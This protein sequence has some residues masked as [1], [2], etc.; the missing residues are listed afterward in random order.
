MGFTTGANLTPP[1]KRAA[2][3][4]PRRSVSAVHRRKGAS[5]TNPNATSTVI[6]WSVPFLPHRRHRHRRAHVVMP[7][8]RQ[9]LANRVAEPCASDRN[10]RSAASESTAAAEALRLPNGVSI[11]SPTAGMTAILPPEATWQQLTDAIAL[12]A[13][14]FQGGAA[15]SCEEAADADDSGRLDLTDAIYLVE[16][17]F[18]TGVAPPA[19]GPLCNACPREY[20]TTP[21]LGCDL[22]SG[23]P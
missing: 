17:L 18:Q 19:P 3:G 22:Y 21:F 20:G 2:Y 10:A 14:L 12:T 5:H 15:P 4:E 11:M 1:P 9:Y 7:D 8:G 6:Q 16:F 23:C 13:R